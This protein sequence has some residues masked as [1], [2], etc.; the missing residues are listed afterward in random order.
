M[1]AYDARMKARI[2]GCA[3]G[4]FACDDE[5]AKTVAISGTAYTFNTP[6]PV[7]GAVVRIVQHPELST[8]TA[9]DGSY[10]IEVP[11]GEVTPYVEHADHVTM[12]LQTF[13]ADQDIERANFQMVIPDI[14]AALSAILSVTPDPTRCQVASTVSAKPIQTMTFAEFL[15]FT[16]AEHG[17]GVAGA[18]VTLEPA[19]ATIYYFNEEVIPDK[20]RTTTSKDGGVVIANMPVGRHVLRA[21]HPERQFVEVVVDCEAGRFINANPAQGLKEL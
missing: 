18:T 13:D 2:I 11:A 17:H 15:A 21:T 7:E 4:L 19:D 6:T 20:S 5:A 8:T 12:H 10:R 16:T 3:L 14:Y 9:A 1:S